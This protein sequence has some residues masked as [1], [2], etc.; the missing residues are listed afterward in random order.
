M[1][2]FLLFSNAVCLKRDC[3]SGLSMNLCMYI[4]HLDDLKNIT[5]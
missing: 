1:T 2:L 3:F 5:G 4:G